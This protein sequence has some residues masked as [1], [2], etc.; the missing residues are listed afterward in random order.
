MIQWLASPLN[1]GYSFLTRMFGIE[2]TEEE[3]RSPLVG[4][5][6]GDDLNLSAS[7]TLSTKN[8]AYRTHLYVRDLRRQDLQQ[9]G[10]QLRNNL[11]RGRKTGVLVTDQVDMNH[12]A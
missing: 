7:M 6:V 11:C 1:Q 9:W 12:C 3:A 10:V 2:Q 8:Y 5:R 4:E